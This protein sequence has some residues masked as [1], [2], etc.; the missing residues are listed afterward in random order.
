[1]NAAGR[2]NNNTS[3]SQDATPASAPQTTPTG[4]GYG[5]PE[6][7]FVQH[8][9]E[10]QRSMTRVETILDEVKKTSGETKDKV[11][12]FEK[13]LYA[14]SAVLVIALAIGGWMLNTVKD[15][16]MT[17]YKASLEQQKPTQ[18]PTPVPPKK[19]GT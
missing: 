3:A 16:A 10:L 1:M 5:H 19:S 12:R 18:V 15:F 11:S 7:H 17:Y 9:M 2:N 13:V 6:Y 8:V 14:A 4:I